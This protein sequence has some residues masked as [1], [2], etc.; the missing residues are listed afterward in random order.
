MLL[1]VGEFYGMNEIY[2]IDFFLTVTVASLKKK[3]QK[4]LKK[5]IKKI[6]LRKNS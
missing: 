5:I 3:L 4:H 2:Y 1:L 6:N